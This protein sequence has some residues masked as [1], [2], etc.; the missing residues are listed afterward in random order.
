MWYHNVYMI[1]NTNIIIS[2]NK[3][4]ILFFFNKI[5]NN[6]WCHNNYMLYKIQICVKTQN[7]TKIYKFYFL[8]IV[9][10]FLILCLI[11]LKVFCLF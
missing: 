10:I 4:V 9:F 7:Q 11:V 5:T 2:K 8:K 1:K 6:V 3:I